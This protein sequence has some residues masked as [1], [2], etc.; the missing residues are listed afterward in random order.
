PMLKENQERIAKGLW[1]QYFIGPFPNY[2]DLPDFATGRYGAGQA[3]GTHWYHA[4]KHGSTSLHILN[5]LAGAFIIEG[6]YDTAIKGFYEKKAN[7]KLVENIFVFQNIDSNLD[8]K[9]QNPGPN[10]TGSAQQL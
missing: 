3:P 2:F 5:G 10:K 8:L 9:R 7:R 4:H 6:D 1:P